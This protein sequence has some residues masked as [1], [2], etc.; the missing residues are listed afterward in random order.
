[1]GVSVLPYMMSCW[2]GRSTIKAV[3]YLHM[4]PTKREAMSNGN[5]QFQK[6]DSGEKEVVRYAAYYDG[7][8]NAPVSYAA[9]ILAMKSNRHNI[10]EEKQ[11][12]EHILNTIEAKI[13]QRSAPQYSDIIVLRADYKSHFPQMSQALVGASG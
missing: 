8:N 9:W 2:W 6:V 4:K 7:N 12:Q 1:M 11:T 13:V 10:A 3:F 5:I